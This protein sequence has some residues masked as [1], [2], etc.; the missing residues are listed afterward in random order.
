VFNLPPRLLSGSTRPFTI[1]ALFEA[2]PIDPTMPEER[3]LLSLVLPPFQRPE[4]WTRAQ[5]ARF[6]E[7]IFLGLGT[8]TYVVNGAEFDASGSPCPCSG[9]L[10]DG[11]QR[12]ASLRA[13]VQ[14]QIGIFDGIFFG[15]LDRRTQRTRFLHTVFPCHELAYT[16]DAAVLMEIYNRMNFGGTP[17][18]PEQRAMAVSA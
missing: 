6:I 3:R 9:W 8:G 17:H 1:G 14:G 12:I 15:D 11:Q 2:S 4:V 18:T 5:Q 16:A 13:F 7:S 10:I